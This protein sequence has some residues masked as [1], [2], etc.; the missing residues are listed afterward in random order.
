MDERLQRRVEQFLDNHWPHMM[1]RVGSLEGQVRL[2]VGI[3]GIT[4]AGIITLLVKA[5]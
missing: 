4:I 3:G 5:W 2:L 1:S